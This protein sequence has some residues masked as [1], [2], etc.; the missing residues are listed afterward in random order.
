MRTRLLLVVLPP[1]ALLLVALGTTLAQS[2][3]GRLSQ[4]RFLEVLGSVE[5]V[6]ARAEPALRDGVG[7]SRLAALVKQDEAVH[8]SAM[9]VI[10]DDASILIDSSRRPRE[11]HGALRRATADALARQLPRR[12]RTAWPWRREPFVLASPVG[13][14]TRIA[15]AAIAFVPTKEIRGRIA[16]RMLLLAAGGMAILVLA[17]LLG[18]LPLARWVLHPVRELT[19]AAQRIAAGDPDANVRERAGP[20][21]LRGLA[22]AFNSMSAAVTAA[23]AR[24]RGF[25]ADA[26]HQLRNPLQSL[27]L[28]LESLALHIRPA[29]EL[30][31]RAALDDIERL[32]STIDVLL[33]LARTEAA[34]A[35]L[36]PVDV[37]RTVAAGV[38]AARPRYADAGVELTLEAG[39]ACTARCNPERVEQALHAVIDNALKF[40]EGAPVDVTVHRAGGAIRVR[41]RDHGPGLDAAERAAAPER[42]WRSARHQN[43][44]GTGLGLALACVLL[45]SCGG[46][47]ELHEAQP[48]LAAEIVLPAA[49][50]GGEA[51]R[52]AS[53]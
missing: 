40:G 30:G 34:A 24:Q 29:G 47:L 50:D 12:P 39:K 11:S 35:E 5:N 38:D 41:V 6:A 1:L 22:G 17:I 16:Q 32:S 25:A 3:A 31:L 27:Q 18:V 51:Q 2:Y 49:E 21:E 9:V 13:S 45:E 43:V 10:A 46:R 52:A 19:G 36:R 4:E 26:S 8:G 44:D 28:R 37:A 7:T 20:P 14:E 33:R 42:F 15:G 23:L 53:R 48:G